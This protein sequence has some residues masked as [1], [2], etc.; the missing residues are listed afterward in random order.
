MDNKLETTLAENIDLIAKSFQKHS[1]EVWE[2]AV[3]YQKTASMYDFVFSV[4]VLLVLWLL[5]LMFISKINKPKLALKKAGANLS[6]ST[7]GYGND[8]KIKIDHD[9]YQLYF[10]AQWVLRG[11]ATIISLIIINGMVEDYKVYTNAKYFAA[12]ELVKIVKH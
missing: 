7:N 10:W 5:V 3:N 12:K 11:A 1:P 8:G 2:Y 4:F 6:D 9:T